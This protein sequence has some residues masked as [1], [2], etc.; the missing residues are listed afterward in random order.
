MIV[1]ASL[2]GI[3]TAEAAVMQAK[4]AVIESDGRNLHRSVDAGTSAA[5]TSPTGSTSIGTFRTPALLG[6]AR[7]PITSS[8]RMGEPLGEVFRLPGEA[9]ANRR[10]LY[11]ALSAR[12]SATCGASSTA[13]GASIPDAVSLVRA[14]VRPGDVRDDGKSVNW[15]LGE[16]YNPPPRTAPNSCS[17]PYAEQLRG[18]AKAA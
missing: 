9:E 8:S 5:T 1:G 12:P 13:S 10:H 4:V 14:A 17:T 16:M 2:A 11:G 15:T 18:D 7:R 3:S 6:S